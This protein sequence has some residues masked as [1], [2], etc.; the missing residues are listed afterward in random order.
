MI[1]VHIHITASS[2]PQSSGLS[3]GE[4]LRLASLNGYRAA[5]LILRHGGLD[6]PDLTPLIDDIKN[7]SL[8]TNME[9]V[10]GVELVH[11]PPALLPQAVKNMRSSGADI[12][13]VHGETLLEPVAEGTNFAAID[14]GA[15][16]LAHPGLIDETAAS[17][18]AERGVALELSSAPRHAFANAHLIAMAR[19]FGCTL[20]PGSSAHTAQDIYPPSL[21][22]RLYQGAGMTVKEL[23]LLR[24]HAEKFIQNKLMQNKKQKF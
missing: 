7:L 12:V 19:R 18:A 9:A 6:V 22:N 15:D 4:A 8:H 16:I 2:A 20:L 1:D 11:I 23:S 5:A 21:R 14:A 13:L 17:Y 24:Q 3:A 10:L